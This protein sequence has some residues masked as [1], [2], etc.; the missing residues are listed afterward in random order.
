MD[1][2]DISTE[3]NEELLILANLIMVLLFAE[4]LEEIVARF[5]QLPLLE[6][7]LAGIIVGPTIL[8]IIHVP[9]NVAVIG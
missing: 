7:L 5:K 4:V 2:T 1:I 6:D 9:A 8:G 3:L